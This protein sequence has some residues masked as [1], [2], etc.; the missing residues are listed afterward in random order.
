MSFPHA[1]FLSF[2]LSVHHRR[3]DPRVSLFVSTRLLVR[4]HAAR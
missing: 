1:I 2:F 4:P 3:S